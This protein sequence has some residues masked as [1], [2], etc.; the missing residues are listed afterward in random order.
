MKFFDLVP[1]VGHVVLE[2]ILDAAGHAE[3]CCSHH[4]C[5]G[6]ALV[7]LIVDLRLVNWAK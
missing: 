6:V 2:L 4:T 3:V 1:S 5:P 7:L